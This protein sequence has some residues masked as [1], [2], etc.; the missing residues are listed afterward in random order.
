MG[1]PSAATTSTGTSSSRTAGSGVNRTPRNG[2]AATS[3]TPHTTPPIAPHWTIRRVT[4]RVPVTSP[5]PRYRPV[6]AWA[7][8]AIAS[9]TKARNVQSVIAIWWVARPTR[10]SWPVAPIVTAYVVTR[11]AARRVSVRITSATAALA[12]ARMPGRSG[13]REAC[14]RRAPRT[15]TASSAAALATC[16]STEPTAEPARP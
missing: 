16:A 6:M 2:L 9:S 5:A 13:R 1:W 14:S 15:T 8:I 7:A 10:S 3:S 11:S 12:A 4:S